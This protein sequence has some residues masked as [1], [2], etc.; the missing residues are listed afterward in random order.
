MIRNRV[1][2]AFAIAVAVMGL[3]VAVTVPVSNADVL[4]NG[5]DVSC[6]KANDSQ[7]VCTVL[8]VSRDGDHAV[9]IRH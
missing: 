3:T 2:A 9:V 7:V 1:M 6:K 4:P 8:T 5:Y